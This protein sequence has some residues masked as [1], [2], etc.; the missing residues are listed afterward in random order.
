MKLPHRIVAVLLSLLLLAGCG[1]NAAPVQPSTASSTPSPAAEPSS[2]SPEDELPEGALEAMAELAR[3]YETCCQGRTLVNGCF[4]DGRRVYPTEHLAFGYLLEKGLLEPYKNQETGCW[5]VPYP[6]LDGVNRLFFQEVEPFY[7]SDLDNI[8]IFSGDVSGLSLP[9]TLGPGRDLRLERDRDDTIALTYHR[10]MEGKVLTPVTYQFVPHRAEEIPPELADLFAPGDTVYQIAGVTQRPDLLP[11]CAADIVEISTAEE[12]LA[13]A[14]RINAGDFADIHNTYRLTADIDL[15]GVAWTPMGRNLPVLE[16]GDERDPN[17]A[18][19]S[20]TFDGQG[21]TIRN[22]TI[23]EEQGRALMGWTA[24]NSPE[25]NYC[26]AGLFY[27]IGTEGVVQDLVLENASVLM[28]LEWPRAGGCAVGIV[29][30]FCRGELRNVAVQ[31]EV[32]GMDGVGGLA[33]TLTGPNFSQ[34]GDTGV[35]TGCTFDGKVTGHSDVGGLVGALHFGTLRN[36]TAYGVVT[37]APVDNPYPEQ[38]PGNIGGVVGHSVGGIVDNC[39]GGA[40]VRTLV[41]S[42]CVG[43]FCGLAEGGGICSSSVDAAKTAGWE[44]VDAYYRLE[45]EYPEVRVS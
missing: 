13:A 2:A 44:P 5:D 45:P 19:F 7:P 31:G 32:Q 6:L 20:G 22:L 43:G 40:E 18:G 17:P 1:G 34:A 25:Q 28:P 4:S 38:I 3:L 36:S 30:A 12:L 14:E 15:A 27:A 33:G 24:Q 11:G 26:G 10:R 16:D 9:Y 29:A 8:A 42:R 35:I 23:T 37:A 41:S 21:H 39:H